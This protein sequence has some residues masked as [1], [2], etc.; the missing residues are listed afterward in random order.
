LKVEDYVDGVIDSVSG[1]IAGYA[2]NSYY[3]SVLYCRILILVTSH[4]VVK[5]KIKLTS[6]EV[7]SDAVY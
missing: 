3:L 5:H 4:F 1:L 7:G 6:G 2:Y